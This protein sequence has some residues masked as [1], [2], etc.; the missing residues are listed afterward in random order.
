MVDHCLLR[1][2][3]CLVW[4]VQEEAWPHKV[5]LDPKHDHVLHRNY[6]VRPVLCLVCSHC[7]GLPLWSQA[8]TPSCIDSPRSAHAAQLYLLDLLLV[9]L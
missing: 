5:H 1:L 4:Q 3:D 2:L 7:M 9:H 8:F 6:R